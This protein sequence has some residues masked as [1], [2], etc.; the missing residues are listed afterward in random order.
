MCSIASLIS[1]A[2][3]RTSSTASVSLPRQRPSPNLHEA[4][5]NR[6]FG[7]EVLLREKYQELK[8]LHDQLRHKALDIATANDD[9][10]RRQ[11]EVEQHAEKLRDH[12]KHLERERERLMLVAGERKIDLSLPALPTLDGEDEDD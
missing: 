6:A 4:L 5:I 1:P 3:F 11:R 2:S 7:G 9:V 12:E 10:N 8:G